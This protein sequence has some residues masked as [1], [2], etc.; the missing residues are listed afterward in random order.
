MFRLLVGLLG[1]AGLVTALPL[2]FGGGTLVWVDTVL[3]DR[4][5]FIQSIEAE[6]EVDG[7]ALVSGPAEIETVPELPQSPIR[8]GEIATI[9]IVAENLDPDVG[10]F[11]GLADT[12]ALETYIGSVPHAV[13]EDVDEDGFTLLYRTDIAGGSPTLPADQGFW[14]ASVSGVGEQTLEWDLE[15]GSYSVLVMNENAADGLAFK[16]TLGARIPLIGPV[17]VGLLIGGGLTLAVGT[18]LLALAL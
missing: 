4:D 5:G 16:T 11:I 14:N 2:L 10:I 3:T 18:L 13:V 17:G 1:I 15:E 6:V 9:R 8:I 12:D 7:F